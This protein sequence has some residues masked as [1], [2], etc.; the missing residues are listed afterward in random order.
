MNMRFNRTRYTGHLYDYDLVPRALDPMDPDTD[1][2]E[3]RYEDGALT[4]S[5]GYL[6]DGF[7][8]DLGLNPFA[9]DSDFDGFQGVIN[10]TDDLD[11][12]PFTMDFDGDG[13]FD[14]IEDFNSNGTY[15][16][17]K[18]E[19]NYMDADTDDDG[20]IDGNE[21]WNLDGLVEP[22]ETDPRT[23]DTDMDGIIDGFEI[24]LWMPQ[25]SG[26]DTSN[27]PMRETINRTTYLT[28]PTDW[29]TDDDGI[30]DGWYDFNNNSIMD[31]GEYEDKDL[32]GMINY[33]AWKNGTGF[34]E[35]DPTNPDSDYDGI[36]DLAEIE[37][38][39]NPIVYDKPDL[40]IF[41]DEVTYSPSNPVLWKNTEFISIEVT[42]K[43]RNIGN[44][45]APAGRHYRHLELGLLF[46]EVLNETS[47]RSI[48]AEY[49]TYWRIG[50]QGSLT[51]SISVPLKA[52]FH[53]IKI[54]LWSKISEANLSNN[55]AIIC[56]HVR[57][58]P[59][60]EAYLDIYGYDIYGYAALNESGVCEVGLIGIG[61]DVDGYITEYLWDINSDG[62][63]DIQSNTTGNHTIYLYSSGMY[64]FTFMVV[65]NDSF[66]TRTVI[67]FHV[68]D[69][70]YVDSDGDNIVDSEEKNHGT[71]PYNSDS[72]KDGLEDGYEVHILGTDPTKMDSDDDGLNDWLE[73]ALMIA[74]GVPDTSIPTRDTDQDGVIDLLDNDSD[75]DGIMDGYEIECDNVDR[76]FDITSWMG[77]NPYNNDTDLDGLSDKQEKICYTEPLNPDTDGDE[78]IDSMEVF[79]GTNPRD[80]DTDNDRVK[81]SYDIQPLYMC[82]IQPFSFYYIPGSIRYNASIYVY[83]F[84]GTAY[85]EILGVYVEQNPSN[86][87]SS[88]VTVE[89]IRNQG[90]WGAYDFDEIS[91]I[92]SETLA[93]VSDFSNTIPNWY[94][95]Y[96]IKRYHYEAS[97]YNEK[98][99][100]L[101]GKS[102]A[103][104][105]VRAVPSKNQTVTIQFRLS[106]DQAFVS[107]NA[108]MYIAFMYDI[109]KAEDVETE[110]KVARSINAWPIYSDIAPAVK[111]YENKYQADILIND[112]ISEEEYLFIKIVPIRILHFNNETW[113][114]NIPRWQ[115]N[116]TSLSHQ[117]FDS[118]IKIVVGR[119]N[120][121]EFNN[122]IDDSVF[123]IEN[124]ERKK[125]RT[126]TLLEYQEEKYYGKQIASYLAVSID[127]NLMT[128]LTKTECSILASSSSFD[129]FYSNLPSEIR[130]MKFTDR[131]CEQV[132]NARDKASDKKTVQ[133][134]GSIEK[135]L[136]SLVYTYDDVE[137]SPILEI[138]IN[139]LGETV[140]LSKDMC[141]EAAKV[142]V[143]HA[144]KFSKATK[145]LEK[146][147]MGLSIAEDVIKIALYAKK[148]METSDPHL[149]KYYTVK[150]AFVIAKLVI[151]V[152]LDILIPDVGGLIVDIADIIIE[153]LGLDVYIEQLQRWLVAEWEALAGECPEEFAR[154][155]FMSACRKTIEFTKRS[156]P[157]AIIIVPKY[158]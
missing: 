26:V 151:R 156:A 130:Q 34:G 89:E 135:M 62:V 60:A 98:Y 127:Q 143:K 47:T 74:F 52:G 39:T 10:C 137:V 81:D 108:Y 112:A 31:P 32:D 49:W 5:S 104:F 7:E 138:A 28:D 48:A 67:Q 144:D 71:D 12:S 15:E 58:P 22:W 157:I 133:V 8:W 41:A 57:A 72:D 118:G 94:V 117:I 142:F 9:I 24:G 147:S 153:Y 33:G 68:L 124:Y 106:R 97:F 35:T 128:I 64:A 4:N 139:L 69:P 154:N 77:T 76:P 87:K 20:I 37:T 120:L 82:N 63:W 75:D 158:K 45:S 140:D 132:L 21:D 86:V 27:W 16:P 2:D 55:D 150:M 103:L 146:V 14:W 141:D 29:D 93:V 13:L 136:K 101:W 56:I 90:C 125:I 88:H 59:T 17:E 119:K 70:S 111:L 42:V 100:E 6:T 126:T 152:V 30:P 116:I 145:I 78:L 102:Y 134:I 122:T 148:I 54:H 107:E 61:K 44:N 65:D 80:P 92:G 109:Y 18:G 85:K 114:E 113:T 123:S 99:V 73:L 155:L 66:A 131:F 84:N 121:R 3:F 115:I 43:I 51:R 19:T 53:K 36:Y 23:N 50:P 91:F 38:G 1:G 105:P 95:E 83:G 149:Q 110:G 96:K 11:P 79:Y 129:Q 46:D 40:A 25:K